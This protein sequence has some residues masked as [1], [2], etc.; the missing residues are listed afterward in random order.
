M[1]LFRLGE[2]A[3]GSRKKY[4]PFLWYPI[5]QRSIE[6]LLETN[7]FSDIF[8]STDSQEIADIA[9][10]AGAKFLGQR[11]RELSD[12]FCGTLEVLQY[13]INRIEGILNGT[14]V[15]CFYPT[16]CLLRPT[17]INAAIDYFGSSSPEI[18]F[19]ALRYSHPIQRALNE[20]GEMLWPENY[21]SR[22]QDLPDYF[23]DAGQ[24][25]LGRANNFL[26]R[27]TILGSGRSH[28]LLIQLKLKILII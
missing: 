5:I 23:H 16:S 22:T 27:N 24:F 21:F 4:P 11:P 2:G 14:S 3:R 12:D 6:L 26:K 9:M 1:Q 13:E 10:G 25:Y 18:L 28:L 19:S 15:C 20:K 17:T 8:V 7:K